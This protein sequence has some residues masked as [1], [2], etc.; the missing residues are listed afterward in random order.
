MPLRCIV[1]VRSLAALLAFLVGVQ[2]LLPQLHRAGAHPHPSAAVAGVGDA[3]E[4]GC[5]VC[6]FLLATGAQALPEP[7]PA[8]GPAPL[9]RAVRR[10]FSWS[11][12]AQAPPAIVWSSP[13]GP[14]TA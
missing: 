8:A 5:S 9:P 13:R 10:I 2:V 14:P 6:Q 11:V 1:A 4:D 7:A 12:R 3:A